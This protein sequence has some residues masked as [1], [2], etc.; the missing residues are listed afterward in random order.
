MDPQGEMGMRVL[1]TGVYIVHNKCSHQG[2]VLCLAAQG[3]AQVLS[4]EKKVVF[5][6]LFLV[7]LL[8]QG[9][10]DRQPAHLGIHDA[11]QAVGQ[12]GKQSRVLFYLRGK[13]S[14]TVRTYENT[15]R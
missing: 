4:A 8:P 5:F 12:S 6:F 1:I 14:N 3:L 2:W 10:E 13:G 9:R 11:I 7:R 15:T